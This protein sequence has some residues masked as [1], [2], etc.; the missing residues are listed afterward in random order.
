MWEHWLDDMKRK[1][2]ADYNNADE[3]IIASYV[4]SRTKGDAKDHLTTLID[5][6]EDD[7]VTA[8]L[9]F[10]HLS[11]IYNNPH[12]AADA[13]AAYRTLEM[14][15]YGNFDEFKSQFIKLASRA[16]VVK[17][18]WKSDMHEKMYAKLQDSV[19]LQAGSDE[20]SFSDLCTAASTVSRSFNKTNLQRQKKSKENGL[21]PK[22]SGS[23]GSASGKA[24][25]GGERQR[26]HTPGTQAWKRHG[27]DEKTAKELDA[28][29]KCYKCQKIGHI[30]SNCDANISEL[31]ASE[32][33]AE[34]PKNG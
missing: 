1:I 11:S 7:E 6:A 20:Y 15:L 25:T 34:Q 4:K 21:N 10:E 19:A 29:R 26:S 3:E 17:D 5:A 22:A 2:K 27:L 31:A 30:A 12:K 23:G 18:D 9:M 32:L 24:N 33:I 28:Q 13:R 16:K 14:K 8:D